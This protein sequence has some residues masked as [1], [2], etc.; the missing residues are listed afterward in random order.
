M[1]R[2]PD[3]LPPPAPSVMPGAPVE[4]ESES[5]SRRVPMPSLRPA[6]SLAMIPL[7]GHSLRRR[8]RD[9]VILH[10]EALFPLPPDRFFR[11]RRSLR[12]RVGPER[13]RP[14]SLGRHRVFLPLRALRPPGP[15]H[16]RAPRLRPRPAALQGG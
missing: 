1:G 2:L 3:P 14:R 6:H 13:L 15:P 8:R 7:G 12:Q 16:R 11:P 10:P 9:E 5:T 4:T